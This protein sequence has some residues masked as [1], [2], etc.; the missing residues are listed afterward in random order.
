[1]GY[2][3]VSQSTALSGRADAGAGDV[4]LITGGQK[5]SQTLYLVAGVVAVAIAVVVFLWKRK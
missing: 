1:M 3:D 4:N 2:V 5:Q